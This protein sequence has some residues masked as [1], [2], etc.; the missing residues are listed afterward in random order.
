MK[1]CLLRSDLFEKCLWSLQ[2]CELHIL[3]MTHQGPH[4]LAP[5]ELKCVTHGFSTRPPHEPGQGPE[6]NNNNKESTYFLV[7]FLLS[8]QVLK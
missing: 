3:E 7:A 1:L 8:V 2:R 4:F 5:R 6:N